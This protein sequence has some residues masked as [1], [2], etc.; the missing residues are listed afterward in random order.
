MA[1]P[2]ELKVGDFVRWDSSG[3][4]ANGKIERI[5]TSGSIDVPGSSFTIEASEDNPAALIQL[6]RNGDPTDQR[7]G[8][9]FSSLTKIQSPKRMTQNIEF[10]SAGFQI[11]DMD[12]R[13]GVVQLYASIFD[14][15]DSDQDRM[16]AGC[17]Q[18][19][20]KEMGPEGTNRIIHLYQH[21]P[22]MPMGRPI[23]L[24]ETKEGL[25]CESYISEM[26]NGDY[27]KM[28]TEGLIKEH[29]IG[30]MG[31]DGGMVENKEGGYDY[32]D[33]TLMEYSSVTWGANEYAR[34][35]GMK[36]QS[37]D[38]QKKEITQ[39][40]ALL[41]KALREHSY[42][43]DTFIMLELRVQRLKAHI[44]N[45]FSKQP[46]ATERTLAAIYESL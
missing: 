27:R 6:Y 32:S 9:R 43:D 21:N 31:K 38:Q 7:V 39:E 25:L 30:F 15:L 26:R 24:E 1:K 45:F 2:D 46:Q 36:S 20:I 34:T 40:V 16:K 17:F 44:D 18:K 42:T 11:K 29:S 19:S 10:K 5:E 22:D 13:Q 4:S 41:E 35:I 12:M 14:V 8:H 37:P 23:K 28:Y 33:V 3:G